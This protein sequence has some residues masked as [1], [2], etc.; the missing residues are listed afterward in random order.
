MD[1]VVALVVEGNPLPYFMFQASKVL[2][3]QGV[4]EDRLS[5]DKSTKPP[6][7][8]QSRR[9]KHCRQHEG[10]FEFEAQPPDE[11]SRKYYEDSQQKIK[12]NR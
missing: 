4:E 7:L 2:M 10:R 11:K 8:I 9:K 12:V 6:A 1:L 5:A 3:P